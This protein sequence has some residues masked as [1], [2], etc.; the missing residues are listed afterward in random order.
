M[1]YLLK[2]S[3]CSLLKDHPAAWTQR[4]VISTGYHNHVKDIVID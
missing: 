1:T 2:K 4:N 3:W